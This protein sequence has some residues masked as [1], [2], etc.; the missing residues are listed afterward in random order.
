MG[1]RPH[2]ARSVTRTSACTISRRGSPANR[3]R[4]RSTSVASISIA[5]TR[6]ARRSSLSVSA[7]GPGP[8]SIT[9]SSPAGHTATAI[10]SRTLAL[11][12]KCCPSFGGKVWRLAPQVAAAAEDHLFQPPGWLAVHRGRRELREQDK[13]RHFFGQFASGELVI[14][15][16][17]AFVNQQGQRHFIAIDDRAARQQPRVIG[18]GAHDFAVRIA[19]LHIPLGHPHR[20][21]I[22]VVAREAERR[23]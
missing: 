15:H 19:P 8:I 11:V 23:D 3:V 10:R 6:A 1:A 9:R 5:T 17:A 18:G 14:L 21:F 16:A 20:R 4:R 22:P 13:T 12:R 7:P 2:W